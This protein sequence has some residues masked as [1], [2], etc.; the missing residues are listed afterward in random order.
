MGAHEMKQDLEAAIH[1]AMT[2][3]WQTSREI[4]KRMGAWSENYVGHRLAMLAEGGE[5]ERKKVDTRMAAFAWAYRKV[6]NAHQA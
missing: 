6:Q 5:V 2:D 4:W 1:K 3:E